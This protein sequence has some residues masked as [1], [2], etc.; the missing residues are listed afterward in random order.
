MFNEDQNASP[1]NHVPAVVVL[2]CMVIGAVELVL[3]AGEYGL[4]GGQNAV[5]WRL[6]AVT[7][8]GFFNQVLSWMLENRKFPAEEMLRFFSYPFIHASFSSVIFAFVLVL[9]M[10]KMVAEVFSQAAF[11]V[12]FF[13]S[14]IVGALVYAAVL[15]TRVP[16]IG[17]YPA[18]YGLIGAW[19]FIMWIRAR[20][21]GTNQ[22]R[23]FNLIG[24][25]VLLQLFFGQVFGG[26]FG[27]VSE[28]SG[29]V[30]GFALSFLLAPGARARFQH[31]LEA[32]RRR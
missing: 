19:T 13:A 23:A 30:T 1:I 3:Q 7:D 16:L 5:G 11:L 6:V 9:A 32:L 15:D 25:L 24:V 26:G 20:H 8:Y 10:G 27:W 18:A 31:W 14:T 28:L 29:F 2:V 22:W 17:A 12:I 4:I 21:D